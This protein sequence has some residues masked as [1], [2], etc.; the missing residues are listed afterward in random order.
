[1]WQLKRIYRTQ[2]TFCH[3]IILKCRWLSPSICQYHLLWTF[4]MRK[5]NISRP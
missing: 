2:R 4:R 3:S 5:G 1:M